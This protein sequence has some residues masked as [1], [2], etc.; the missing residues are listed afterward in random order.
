VPVND[1]ATLAVMTEVHRAAAEGGTLAEG[2]L[3]ARRAGAN[4]PLLAATAAAFTTW[5]A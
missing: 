1:V 3:A 5:G 2:W 4:D